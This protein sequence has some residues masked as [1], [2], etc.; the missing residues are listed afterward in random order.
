[1]L[2][3]FGHIIGLNG[4]SQVAVMPTY[5]TVATGTIVQYVGSTDANYTNGYFYKA[6]A[7]GWEVVDVQGED[8]DKA[9]KVDSATAGNLAGLNASGNLTDAG[10][11]ADKTTTSATGN[12]ISISGLKSNQLAINPVITLEP[13]QAG[14]GDPSPSNV[15]AIS[16]YD[17]IEV[18]SCGKNIL[19]LTVEGIKSNN[20]TTWN[21]NSTVIGD[22]T[23]TIL[24]DSNGNVTGINANGTASI[25]VQ[26]YIT[27]T[28]GLLAGNYMLNGAISTNKRMFFFDG[29]SWYDDY[30][31]GNNFTI[32]SQTIQ[33][34]VIVITNGTTVSNEVFYPM[35]R[36]ASITDPTFE[37]YNPIT[38]IQLTLGQT[39]YGGTLDVEKGILTVD[40]R[41]NTFKWSAGTT[42]YTEDGYI[43]KSF[44]L[45]DTIVGH[46][47]NDSEAKTNIATLQ[48]KWPPKNN[49][50]IENGGLAIGLPD[51]TDGNTDIEIWYKIATPYEIQLT[52]HEISLLKDYAYVSTNG[53]NMSF[54][55]KNGELAS[56]G[57]VAQLGQTVNE[58]A[59]GKANFD[60]SLPIIDWGTETGST[61]KEQMVRALC[62]YIASNKKIG[63]FVF[64]LSSMTDGLAISGYENAGVGAYDV[65]FCFNN[66]MGIYSARFV[67]QL[68]LLRVWDA[69]GNT[70]ATTG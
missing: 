29:T 21:G 42:H 64:E 19:P 24:T 14:S 35:I 39:I 16:G 45:E 20:F 7:S 48:Y 55:Y 6:T 58:L 40:S 44:T 38:N 2:S 23:F 8:T 36:L 30:G 56:L 17:K 54:S 46:A 50:Y 13:I 31:S 61:D 49:F 3:D 18:L 51:T 67:P 69:S 70:I 5:S 15:R 66:G 26:F 4:S 10:W 62:R 25:E 57:D 60:I 41:K 12:P 52:P 22:V 47:Y 68:T 43:A 32:S 65:I 63:V 53:T 27:R 28:A 34:V 1:M 33:E 37:P 9:D 59:E 11:S